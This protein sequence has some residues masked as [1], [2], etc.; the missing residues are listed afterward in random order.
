M[1]DDVEIRLV[2]VRK[3]YLCAYEQGY[4]ACEFRKKGKWFWK[5]LL[6][7][8]KG[9][10]YEDNSGEKEYFNKLKDY[11]YQMCLEQNK[12]AKLAYREHWKKVKRE[13]PKYTKIK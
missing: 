3:E 10:L 1:K 11:D 7:F 5:R 12:S 2:D 6:L 4:Y 13:N 8:Y 9:V